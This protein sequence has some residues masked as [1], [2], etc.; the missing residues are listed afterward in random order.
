MPF[1]ED[2]NK[3]A[4][5]F[6]SFFKFAFV[7]NPRD[8]IISAYQMF[9]QMPHRKKQINK[10]FKINPDKL[11]FQTFLKLAEKKR[12]HHWE[13]QI[14]YLPFCNHKIK[15]DF[16]GHL[17]TFDKDWKIIKKNVKTLDLPKKF[18][19][20]DHK[21]PNNEYFDQTSEKIFQNMF[22]NDIRILNY[23]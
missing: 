23:K 3:A 6:N 8:R 14:N 19:K 2:K 1:Y 17:E 12:N 20:T 13:E 5:K 22:K 9:T 16:L 11:S 18:N 10:L 21:K 7:R 15:L 4:K